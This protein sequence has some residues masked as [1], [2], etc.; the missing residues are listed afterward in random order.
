MRFLTALYKS[1]GKRPFSLDDPLLLWITLDQG[2]HFPK[3]LAL[4]RASL[5]VHAP[6][7]HGYDVILA[8]GIIHVGGRTPLD[9]LPLLHKDSH[10]ASL[11]LQYIH[12]RQLKHIGGPLTLKAES[13]RFFWLFRG[14]SLFKNITRSCVQ[15]VRL[16]PRPANQIM[17]PLPAFRFDPKGPG[18]FHHISIDFA[19]P[20]LCTLRCEPIPRRKET[21]VEAKRYILVICCA[22]YRAVRCVPTNGKETS[23]VILA[24]QS[25]ASN[26]RIPSH[27]HSDNAAEFLRV[28]EELKIL[29]SRS[30]TPLPISPDW[31]KVTWTFGHPRA[32]HTN[33]IVESLVGV[34]KRALSHSLA[35]APLTDAI[36]RTALSF[37][38]QVVNLR[39]L[40]ALSDS[41]SDPQPLTP[42]MFIGHQYNMAPLSVSNRLSHSDFVNEWKYLEKL[43][44]SF[45]QRFFTELVPEMTKRNKWWAVIPDLKVDQVVIVLNCPLNQ[46]GLWPLGRVLSVRRGAD[47]RV[48]GANVLVKGKE[49]TRHIKH[50]A[51][52]L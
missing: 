20:W 28:E 23:D 14:S 49:Y 36:F 3:E 2:H 52:L 22:V 45:A 9:P 27:I 4:L 26:H 46:F 1:V 34:T 24:L 40:G 17:A 42:G 6:T 13:R 18:A 32:P 48:R 51:P 38:E 47:G 35:N 15:C 41:P 10:L 16:K 50:L 31:A 44:K 33:G 37:A 29:S 21:Y 12:T 8:H 30:S 5:P 39:P 25:F 11:W 19:G 43:Q 7:W